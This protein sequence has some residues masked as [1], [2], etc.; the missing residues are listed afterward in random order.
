MRAPCLYHHTQVWVVGGWY[1]LVTIIPRNEYHP[2]SPLCVARQ[3]AA[4][5]PFAGYSN[6][7]RHT[8]PTSVPHIYICV[9]IYTY[10]YISIYIY[11]A[12][13]HGYHAYHSHL[14][15]IS[16][17]I[18]IYIHR[19]IYHTHICICIHWYGKLRYDAHGNALGNVHTVVFLF[20]FMT[21]ATFAT[22]RWR[23][24]SRVHTGGVP[25]VALVFIL[26]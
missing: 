25:L 18:S 20:W 10:T 19:C 17:G 24:P 22:C 23:P 11:T 2:L 9:Y 26:N 7:L 1:L 16:V 4:S 5:H 6:N 14:D 12:R 15:H 3:L 21:M 13:L 8:F